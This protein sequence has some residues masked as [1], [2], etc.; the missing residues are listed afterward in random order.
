MSRW[1][2]FS[3]TCSGVSSSPDMKADGTAGNSAR[4]LRKTSVAAITRYSAANS[5][6]SASI[7]AM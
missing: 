2:S 5:T 4:D 6:S 3:S 7:S 1:R